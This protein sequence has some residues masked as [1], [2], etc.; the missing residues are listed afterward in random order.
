MVIL[1]TLNYDDW[2]TDLIQDQFKLNALKYLNLYSFKKGYVVEKYLQ[3]TFNIYLPYKEIL[4]QIIQHIKILKVDNNK[5]KLM[6]DKNN[7]VE[8]VSADKIARILFYGNLELKGDKHFMDLLLY[9]IHK[10]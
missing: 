8:N 4:K 3:K 5:Y 2:K 9:S 10:L 6:I 1:F 7:K